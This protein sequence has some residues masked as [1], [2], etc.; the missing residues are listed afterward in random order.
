MA[1]LFALQSTSEGSGT[2]VGA[3]FWFWDRLN[4]PGQLCAGRAPNPSAGG[5]LTLP[6]AC[7]LGLGTVELPNALGQAMKSQPLAATP[8]QTIVTTGLAAC[9]YALR[10]QPSGRYWP[11]RW[12]CNR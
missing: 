8:E 3:F 2:S 1:A 5:Q 7:P 11:A 6:V 10:V 9:L 12:C 4:T